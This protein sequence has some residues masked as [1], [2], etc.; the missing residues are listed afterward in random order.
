MYNSWLKDPKRSYH[1]QRFAFIAILIQEFDGS[2]R[3]QVETK[4]KRDEMSSVR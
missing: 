3:M 1:E 2:S 4:S